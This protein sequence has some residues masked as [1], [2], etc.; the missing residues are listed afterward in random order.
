MRMDGITVIQERRIDC[1][2]NRV[3]K[4]V[5]IKEENAE[6]KYVEKVKLYGI[7]DLKAMLKEAGLSVR[8]IAGDYDMSEFSTHS[9]RL[10]LLAQH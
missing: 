3:I 7:N 4:D 1:A 8:H 9:P 10:I 5:T 6:R 2:A